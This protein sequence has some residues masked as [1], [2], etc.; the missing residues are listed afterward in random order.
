[1][2]SADLYYYYYYICICICICIYMH[3]YVCVHLQPQGSGC[4]GPVTGVDRQNTWNQLEFRSKEKSVSSCAQLIYIIII[5]VYVYV[6]IC[7][8]VRV[9]VH[10]HIYMK[11]IQ[12]N[13]RK[14]YL[15]LPSTL[16]RLGTFTQNAVLW[17]LYNTIVIIILTIWNSVIY[18]KVVQN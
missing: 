15:L 18:Y 17:K 9:C 5:Y 10:L 16:L 13:T 11:R 6:Y 2:C 3:V 4:G 14:S 7:I 1:L 12:Y 8:C